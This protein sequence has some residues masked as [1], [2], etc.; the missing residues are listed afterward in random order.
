MAKWKKAEQSVNMQLDI[1]RNQQAMFWQLATKIT[2][3]M[4]KKWKFSQLLG[5]RDVQFSFEWEGKNF[6]W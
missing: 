3:W 4:A 1:T 2:H 5:I 6:R